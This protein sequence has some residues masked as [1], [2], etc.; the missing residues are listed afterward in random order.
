TATEKCANPDVRDRA[1]VYWR[2]L[3]A[4][5]AAARSVALAEKS[6]PLP[7][8][9]DLPAPL[10]DEL[11][12]ELGCVS[13]VLQIPA[14]H[15]VYTKSERPGIPRNAALQPSLDEE[16]PTQSGTDNAGASDAAVIADGEPELLISF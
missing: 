13:S 2:L 9:S 11:V 5:P 14:P 7:V 10:L 12:A 3:S 15:F 4:D 8:S 1:Y 6:P 16:S